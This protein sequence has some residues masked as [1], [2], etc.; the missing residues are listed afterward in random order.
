M[1]FSPTLETIAPIPLERIRGALLGSAVGDALG[2]T[3]EFKT[4]QQ[5]QQ[6]PPVTDLIGG[7][8]LSLPAG[9]ITDDTQM[10]RCVLQSYAHGYALEDVASR[11]LA[12]L[13][14]GPA[15]VGILTRQ[16]LGQVQR[17]ISPRDAGRIAWEKSGFSSAGN[18]AIMRCAP[19]GVLRLHDRE[20]RVLETVEIARLTH[21]DQRCVESSVWQNAC[22]AALIAGNGVTAA[23]E[24][25]AGEVIWARN[26]FDL[27]TPTLED[28]VLEWVNKAHDL[29]IAAL[30]TSG[31]TLA[32]AQVGAWALL[33]ADTLEAGL[34]VVT[35][36]GGDADTTGAVAG[37][38]LGAK[39]GASAI[40]TRWLGALLC[41]AE[42]EALIGAALRQVAHHTD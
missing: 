1:T 38:L 25:A 36:Q 39:F 41:C 5:I 8:W 40:P 9:E 31:Y 24:F 42:L 16:A 22:I 12:W 7:G 21:F 30:D 28:D 26:A 34:I 14:S 29:P 18:G 27:L 35:N 11:F 6:H 2:A 23:L 33:H 15:D 32:T 10:M 37:A 17:G 19:T 20:A 4:A 13:E 3:N